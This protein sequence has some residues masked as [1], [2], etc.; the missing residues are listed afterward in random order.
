VFLL[1]A[2]YFVVAAT[3]DVVVVVVVVVVAAA[4]VLAVD[5]VAATVVVGGG[6]AVVVVVIASVDV[7]LVVVADYAADINALGWSAGEI[8]LP[9]E[10]VFRTLARA[11]ICPSYVISS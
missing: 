8:R 3:I 10:I 7:A 2:P 4:V 5:V 9:V 6:G 1:E 11:F